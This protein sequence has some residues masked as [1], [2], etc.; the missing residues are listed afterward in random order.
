MN[1]LSKYMKYF[2]VV[3]LVLEFSVAIFLQAISRNIHSGSIGLLI[4]F[5]LPL[6]VWPRKCSNW[7]AMSSTKIFWVCFGIGSSLRIFWFLFSGI[8]QTSDASYYIQQ[9][10]K[11]LGLEMFLDPSKQVGPGYMIAISKIIFPFN[12]EW[13]SVLPVLLVS[14]LGMVLVFILTERLIGLVPACIALFFA[15]FSPEHILYTNILTAHWFQSFW[16]LAGLVF[17]VNSDP[18]RTGSAKSLFLCGIC[19]G[20]SQYMRGSSIY[21]ILVFLAL[22][23]LW[24]R[25]WRSIF[26]VSWVFIVVVT[27]ILV[28]NF[29]RLGLISLSPSQNSGFSLYL[30]TD[31]ETR[32]H[33]R[34]NYWLDLINEVERLKG[35]G[36]LPE[37]EAS[38]VSLNKAGTKM[39][40]SRIHEQ[41]HRFSIMAMDKLSEF[42][43]SGASLA[44]S[45]EG[46][47]L[48]TS[49]KSVERSLA[50]AL[51]DL[52]HFSI[53][54]TIIGFALYAK[55]FSGA[56]LKIISIFMA[57]S[58]IAGIHCIAEVQSQ[59]HMIVF[60]IYPVGVALFSDAVLKI[61]L[62]KKIGGSTASIGM[63]NS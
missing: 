42:W 20:L 25:R 33:Y 5:L 1:T 53:F 27:P 12:G 7:I 16:L 61:F 56:S 3:F 29:T 9:S 19:F 6:I 11:I 23:A 43:A 17:W 37:G 55:F 39:A 47:I 49:D 36:E 45:L 10:K 50:R 51:D 32:G 60:W 30:G 2:F 62:R 46:S 57:A 52:A 14:L 35:R 15:A 8:S 40:L 44:W 38:Q 24:L 54:L 21:F 4:L 18:C 41:P 34:D 31:F 63:D 26:T 48:E 28:F 59:Y 13:V 58:A 22:E